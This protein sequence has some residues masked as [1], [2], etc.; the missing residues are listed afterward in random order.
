MPIHFDNH[1]PTLQSGVVGRAAGLHILDNRTMNGVRQ[2]HLVAV[3]LVQ[4]AEAQSPAAFSVFTAARCV[5][6]GCSHCFQR[7][8]NVDSLAI[9]NDLESD[10]VTGTLLSDFHLQLSGIRYGL[11]VQL[12]NDVAGFQTGFPSR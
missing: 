9:T 7:D 2:L 12:G 6:G 4:V 3:T 10:G 5:G 1:I 8:W 11:S